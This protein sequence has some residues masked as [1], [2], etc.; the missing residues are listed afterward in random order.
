MANLV[1]KAEVD[2][3]APANEVWKALTDPEIIARYFFGSRV[4]TS[5]KPGTPIRWKGEWQG[6][7]YED[8]GQILEFRPNRRLKV[9][10]F[11]P[12]SAVPDQPENYHTITYELEEH[13]GST[14]LSLM[15]DNNKDES[16]VEH[17]TANWRVMLAGLKKTVEA[18][19]S[20]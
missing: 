15:Q 9:T 5:W 6:R 16:E 13:G 17:S 8:K 4:E 19:Q 18:E 2:I 14:H 1:A 11:S 3:A 12:L 20:L 10:H 7:P